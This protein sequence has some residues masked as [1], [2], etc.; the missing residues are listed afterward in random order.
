MP[1]AKITYLSAYEEVNDSIYSILNNYVTREYLKTDLI[2]TKKRKIKKVT[3]K[4]ILNVIPKI[5]PAI[6]Y[7]LKGGKE[8]E[9]DTI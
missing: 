2:D 3:K 7:L 5:H 6:V 8:N 1:N 9:K 4:D